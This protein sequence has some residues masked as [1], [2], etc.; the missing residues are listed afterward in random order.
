MD[1]EPDTGFDAD[2]LI[3]IEMLESVALDRNGKNGHIG[4]V[5]QP[6]L[7][8]A[9]LNGGFTPDKL[10]NLAPLGLLRKITTPDTLRLDGSID[11]KGKLVQIADH[12]IRLHNARQCRRRINQ[13]YVV[14]IPNGIEKCKGYFT[15]FTNFVLSCANGCNFAFSYAIQCAMLDKKIPL[16]KQRDLDQC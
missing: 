1:G 3:Q 12:N 10:P 14:I 11:L 16:Q 2:H 7:R 6:N 5:T 13:N 9:Y 4:M 15:F 8:L